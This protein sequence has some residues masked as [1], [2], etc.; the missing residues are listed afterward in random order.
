MEHGI[1][2]YQGLTRLNAGGV[3]GDYVQ[4]EYAD[5]DKLYL[6]V[7]RLNLLQLYRGPQEKARLDK[8]G[9][10]VGKRFERRSRMHSSRWPISC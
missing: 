6:P 9:E 1:G 10:F 2:R 5:G 8:L 4:L 3:P 7:Y